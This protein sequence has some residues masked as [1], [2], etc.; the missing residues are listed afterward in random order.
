MN[1][2]K[3]QNWEAQKLQ[4]EK[5]IED[6]P[7]FAGKN[8]HN[9]T[10]R[11]LELIGFCKENFDKIRIV[12]VAGTNG[13]G[14]VCAYLSNT[15]TLAGKKTGLFISPHLV[16]Y[17]ERIQINGEMI[18]DEEFV[19]AFLAVREAVTSL[20]KEG[21]S[22]PSFF[23]FLFGMGMYVFLKEKVEYIIL[24]TG[25][26]GRLDATNCIK[27][28]FLTVITSVS[29]DHM[30]ILGDTLEKIAAEKAGIIKK[31]VPVVYWGE[32]DIVKRVIENAA[33]ACDSQAILVDSSMISD[34]C[35]KD[36]CI[37]FSLDNRYYCKRRIKLSTI[38]LYQTENASLAATALK[39]IGEEEKALNDDIIASGLLKTFWEG[40]MEQILPDVYL[41]GAHNEDG[42]RQF[43]RTAKAMKKSDEGISQVLMFSAVSDKDFDKMIEEICECK[44]FDAYVVSTVKDAKRAT[45]AAELKAVFDE[46]LSDLFTNDEQKPM[47]YACDEAEEAFEKILSLKGEGR[48]FVVGSLYLV[49]TIKE[50]IA[51]GDMR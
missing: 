6:I 50:I 38:A 44:A 3:E 23:E 49:G 15:L 43:V 37:D 10:G 36:N 45:P 51:M 9:N 4:A 34:I 19:K 26:G 5:Y 11:F 48:A 1:T 40:R 29:F 13:K 8:S 33:V 16:K 21:Y 22:H 28:P 46:K 7:K 14:S 24:E 2:I 47:V 25:L 41:D 20:E 42:I 32:N 30:Y 27:N 17:N 31:G 12:H 18:S 39:V 35:C